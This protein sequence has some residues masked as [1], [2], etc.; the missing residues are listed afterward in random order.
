MQWNE[1]F[2]ENAW[3]I[4]TYP[5]Y[6][7]KLKKRVSTIF[8]ATKAQP[9]SALFSTD[10]VNFGEDEFIKIATHEFGHTLGLNHSYNQ[11]K[12][13]DIMQPV[14]NIFKIDIS[15]RDL[16]TLK[17]LYSFPPKAKVICK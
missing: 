9:G 2:K 11:F 14:F 7:A 5:H 6:D 16:N 8:L 3:G 10:S 15:D 17:K 1:Y 12:N 13:V 4:S